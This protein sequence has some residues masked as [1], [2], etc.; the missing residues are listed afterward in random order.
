MTNTQPHQ[1][2]E[3]SETDIM[4]AQQ[5]SPDPHHPSLIEL[6]S[7]PEVDPCDIACDAMPGY[8]LGDLS[9][10]ETTWVLDHTETCRY[11]KS[12]LETF[13][14]VDSALT[15]G[16]HDIDRQHEANLPP[17]AARVLG[18]REARYGFMDT[19]LGPIVIVTTDNG[20]CD[21]SYLANSAVDDVLR[22][23][24]SRGILATEKQAFVQPVVEQLAEYFDHKRVQFFLPIDLFGVTPFTRSVLE[25]TNHVPSGK[26]VTYGQVAG[27]IG[28]PKASRAVGNALGRNP[29]PIVVPCHRV[30]KS[31]GGM[32]WYT[33]GPH[34]KQQLLDIEG[35]HFASPTGTSQ[36]RLEL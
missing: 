22:R 18:L 10:L 28:Q 3:S 26:V 16:H 2:P 19:Q 15:S 13:E 20:V 36:Q 4:T 33:G 12:M 5:S 25:V 8:V 6:A 9:Q 27:C 29:I 32:G 31:D 24:E 30:I 34:L 1:S 11:C 7:R 21:I 17:S 14:D 23:V 35:V